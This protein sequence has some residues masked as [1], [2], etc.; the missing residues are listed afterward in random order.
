MIRNLTLHL[1]MAML[2]LAIEPTSAEE[3]DQLALSLRQRTEK[4][5]VVLDILVSN[6][7]KASLDITS[8]GIVPP[9]SV[10]AWFD[11]T[12]DGK[13]AKF[14]ENVAGIPEAK[15]SW[16]VPPQGV[17]LWASVPLRKLEIK[18]TDG[19]KKAIRGKKRRVVTIFPTERWKQL[20]VTSAKIEV[21]QQ[22]AEPVAAPN[23]AE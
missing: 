1:S 13:P 11:W 22:N 15:E 23:A 18:T 8:K 20:K 14:I 17:I 6:V 5:E 21:G 16:R 19:Y 12:V 4:G 7:S 2:L 3:S 9:W 10:W